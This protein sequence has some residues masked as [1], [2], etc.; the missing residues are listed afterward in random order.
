MTDSL[1][2]CVIQR[3]IIPN[4]PASNL[5][6]TLKMLETCAEQDVDFFVLTEH[7]STGLLDRTAPDN[8]DLAEN[9]DGP[10]VD[11]LRDFCR[12]AGAYLLAG[13]LPIRYDSGLRNTALMINPVGKIILECSK[14]HLFKP[15]G[16]T[17]IYE[18]GDCLGAAEIA[19]IGVGV[20][21]CYDLRFPALAR[22]LAHAGCEVIAVPGLWPEARISHWETLLRARAI[23]NQ[24]WMIGANGLGSLS[25]R[26][27]PGHS[28]IVSPS[29]DAINKPEMRESAIVR[30]L[31]ISKLRN[32]RRELC[33]IDEERE[34]T[35]VLWNAGVNE[36]RGDTV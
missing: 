1:T 3:E 7:W 34:I 12:E 19:G 11:A 9:I 2:I 27:F 4:D 13:T 15:M 18:P 8:T 36:P 31:D 16:E 26:F 35:E 25:G 29:G 21:I 23:E 24:V 33:H 28:M 22:R 30:K 20:L 6:G 10:T 5:L 14:I 17:L 32:L